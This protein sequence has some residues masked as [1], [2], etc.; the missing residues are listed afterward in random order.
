M[1]HALR[2]AQKPH[3]GQH[4]FRP[5]RHTGLRQGWLFADTYRSLGFTDAVNQSCERVDKDVQHD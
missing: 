2:S 5:P 4:M 1:S 3:G